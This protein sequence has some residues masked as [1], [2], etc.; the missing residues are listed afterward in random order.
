M[1]ADILRAQGNHDGEYCNLVWGSIL[2]LLVW[3]SH[4]LGG[5]DVELK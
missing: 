1:I 3:H 5:T 4:Y 2:G